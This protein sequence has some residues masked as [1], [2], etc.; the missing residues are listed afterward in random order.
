MHRPM[1]PLIGRDR[2]RPSHLKGLS[3]LGEM[4][5]VP[6]TWY[7]LPPGLVG[8]QLLNVSHIQLSSVGSGTENRHAQ[9]LT[10]V[11]ET[12][13]VWQFRARRPS[14]LSPRRR[15]AIQCPTPMLASCLKSVRFSRISR[16]WHVE[17]RRHKASS[18]QG[19][20][21]DN[22]TAACASWS[23]RCVEM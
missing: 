14:R 23:I 21:L 11:H 2:R 4:T 17:L 9:N 13:Q 12:V 10:K 5:W 6:S 20:F 16:S 1:I 22:D 18:L 8:S 3:L 7:G 19:W 15:S